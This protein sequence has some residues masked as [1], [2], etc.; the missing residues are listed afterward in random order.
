MHVIACVKTMVT[1]ER[2]IIVSALLV[3]TFVPYFR[4]D[5]AICVYAT[6]WARFVPIRTGR[7]ELVS[8]LADWHSADAI[9]AIPDLARNFLKVVDG[10]LPRAIVLKVMPRLECALSVD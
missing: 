3:S 2:M 1:R 6:A 4:V 5:P 10:S 8:A 9:T 7:T